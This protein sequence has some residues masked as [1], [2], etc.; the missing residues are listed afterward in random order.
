LQITQAVAERQAKM[1]KECWS[2]MREVVGRISDQC[3]REKP[4][5]HD[6][7]MENAR[8]LVSVLSGLNVTN[9]PEIAAAEAEIKNLIVDPEQLRVS[10]STRKRVAD[11][12][13]DLRR[14]LA[15]RVAQREKHPPCDHRARTPRPARGTSLARAW[16]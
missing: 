9:D 12:A 13:D 15:R 16:T 10:P 1:V 6:S 5:I 8:D 11:A 14:R 2:R 3:S 7:L 4:R